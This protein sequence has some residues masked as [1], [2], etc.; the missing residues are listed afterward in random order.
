MEKFKYI[1]VPENW[2][3]NHVNDLIVNIK[4]LSDYQRLTY[5]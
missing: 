5:Y 2:L 1:M 3:L 4:W